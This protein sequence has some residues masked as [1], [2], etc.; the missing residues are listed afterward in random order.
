MVARIAAVNSRPMTDQ[1]FIAGYSSKSM[2]PPTHVCCEGL[3]W[4]IAC[5]SDRIQRAARPSSTR[6]GKSEPLGHLRSPHGLSILRPEAAHYHTATRKRCCCITA[7]ID[8]RMAEMGVR[9]GRRPCRQLLASHLIF[10]GS[11]LAFH[12]DY[13]TRV[14]TSRLAQGSSK[15]DSLGKRDQEASI[16]RQGCRP[17]HLLR[18]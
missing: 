5:S 6:L 4:G 17:V 8:R 13:L 1:A 3:G 11:R 15:K 10:L 2:H 12:A 7:K 18:S 9:S 16:A 14:R